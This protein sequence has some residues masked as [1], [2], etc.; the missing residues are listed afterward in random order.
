MITCNLIIHGKVQG[1]FFR[2]TAK[3]KALKHNIGG[4][5]RNNADGTVEA[6]VTGEEKNVQAFIEWCKRG[7]ANALVEDVLVTRLDLQ[8][9]SD[10]VIT[11]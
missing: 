1:V 10:F 3:E 7:P 8:D 5:I 11:H 6:T 4:W 2:N 9:F